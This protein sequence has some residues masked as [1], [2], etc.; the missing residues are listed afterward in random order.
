M[1][2]LVDS[3]QT[4]S[5]SIYMNYLFVLSLIMCSLSS[6]AQIDIKKLH[7]KLKSTHTNPLQYKISKRH[8]FNSVDNRNGVVCSAYTPKECKTYNKSN[9]NFKLNTEH[10]WPQ[11]KG[12]KKF[13]AQGDMHHLY[14]T[15]KESN[16]VRENFPFC[17]VVQSYWEKQGSYQGFNSDLEDCFEPCDSHKGNV[18]RAMFYF[19]I[20]YKKGLSSSQEKLFRKWNK[21]DPVDQSEIIRNDRIENIQGNRNP[22]IDDETIVDQISTFKF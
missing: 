19:A 14:A 18:A 1:Y 20:R 7:L 22:F 4:V 21:L 5:Y 10:T 2:S 16:S 13:P 12:A 3:S 15:S 6:Y 17:H 8:I 11:S 9:K